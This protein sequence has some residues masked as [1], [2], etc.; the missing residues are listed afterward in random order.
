MM[1]GLR[2]QP[3]FRIPL[4]VSEH[5]GVDRNEEPVRSGI[6][7]P[8]SIGL[9]STENLRLID[10]TGTAVP[11]H[12][13]VLGRW[14]GGPD[15]SRFP[16]RWLQTDFRANLQSGVT[17][18]YTLSNE[19]GGPSLPNVV[20]HET[21]DSI[22]LETG[23]ARFQVSKLRGS[24]FEAV[25]LDGDGDGDDQWDAP[26]VMASEQSGSYVVAGG[27]E[28]RASRTAPLEVMVDERLPGRVTLRVEG[29]HHD[30]NGSP[31]LRYVTRL[32][33]FA[34]SS[35]VKVH[36]TLIEGRVWGSG[37]GSLYDDV[38]PE[39]Q[40]QI[41][42]PIE[43][44]GLRLVLQAPVTEV[45]W[46]VEDGNSEAIAMA[47]GGSLALRQRTP[48]RWQD[49]LVSE[50]L[51][52][53]QVHARYGAAR[54]ALLSAKTQERGG[55][56]VSTRDFWR[57]GPQ[58]IATDAMGTVTVDFPA[59][60]YTIYQAMGL[61]EEI[62]FEFQRGVAFEDL[63]ASS[64]GG[65]KDP[66]FAVA[67]GDWY[68]ASGAF[69]ELAAYPCTDYPSYDEGME[70]HFDATRDWIEEGHAYGLLNWLDMPIIR[71]DDVPDPH[72]VSYGNSYY[73]A[74]GSCIREF[75]RRGEYRWLRDL[76][77]PQIRHWYTTD[78]YDT[79]E[80][81]HPYDGISGARGFYHRSG[82]TGEYH[83]MESLWDYYYLTGDRRA[84]ERGLRA[85]RSYAEDPNWDNDFDLG[86]E[87]PGITGRMVWQKLNTLLE[88]WRASGQERFY[89]IMVADAEEWLEVIGTEHGFLR[90]D[91]QQGNRFVTEQHFQAVVI[92][93]P[94]LWKYHAL[95]QSEAARN[96]LI[97]VPRHIL[98]HARESQDPG[99][100]AYN[101]F[102]NFLQVELQEDAYTTEPA[103]LFN[104]S[105]DYLYDPAAVGLLAALGRA[106]ALTG[107]R[108]LVEEARRLYVERIE[109]NW[110]P[111]V[112][113]KANAQQTLRMA[114]AMAY[115]VEP[116]VRA[117]ASLEILR[118]VEGQ[119][120]L[121]LMG[122]PG[123]SYQVLQST[124]LANWTE[125]TLIEMG[126]EGEVVITDLA[127]QAS[128][129]FYR[130]Q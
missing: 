113:D 63:F 16:I 125:H 35:A 36:H 57:K 107:D 89:E 97:N 81:D 106:S 59:E 55:V 100:P 48:R 115:L 52:Q 112:W 13:E 75:A 66:L 44:A 51:V 1:P 85:A 118:A 27:Q 94:V 22:Q 90:E 7:F 45:E 117:G 110:F 62:L 122:E 40:A 124:D 96:I 128:R 104:N 25:W 69:G 99:S 103:L 5:A 18:A 61:A 15:D 126:S 14:G 77:F 70:E 30:P 64:Q 120:R 123:Q 116:R 49:P 68:V 74:P 88:A 92:H 33:F 32:T 93:L 73:D 95:T 67:S 82:F 56:A 54:S 86:F 130:L 39:D 60:P 87:I 91:R 23:V 114:P 37:N 46:T 65:L 12:F 47:E 109:P 101:E 34:G 41:V 24:L 98:Q 11:A 17:R 31:L 21:E 111:N 50:V 58:Q 20:V 129:L 10:D 29:F 72:E 26:L 3:S 9:L 28:Y 83:Y 84:L 108:S 80:S 19:G 43:K 79:D 78:T 76:A 127:S 102:Y 53:G 119:I 105:D 6:P 121:R 2:A 4:R 8:E 71:F 38:A 42:T